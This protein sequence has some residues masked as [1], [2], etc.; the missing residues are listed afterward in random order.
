MSQEPKFAPTVLDKMG[1]VFADDYDRL[2][3]VVYE[4][5]VQMIGALPLEPGE[6]IR[7]AFD[8][9]ALASKCARDVDAS[10]P[11]PQIEIDKSRERAWTNIEQARRHIIAGS[12]YCVEHQ[13]R[14]QINA[15]TRFVDALNWAGR[16]R[17]AG[18]QATADSLEARLPSALEINIAPSTERSVNE[19][20][21]TETEAKV[22]EITDLLA[23][24]M[25]LHLDVRQTIEGSPP[26]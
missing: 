18:F 12:F 21:T 2:F 20:E 7:N 3:R 9:F 16:S 24:Y 1:H 15:I 10:P 17:V 6:E 8:H 25:Q 11:P 4:N 26:A 5:A 19:R 13:L 23:D 22:R 14:H